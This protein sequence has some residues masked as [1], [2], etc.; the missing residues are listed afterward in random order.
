MA[1]TANTLDDATKTLL[2]NMFDQW[3]ALSILM[4]SLLG[5]GGGQQDVGSLARSQ[6]EQDTF[7]WVI[8]YLQNEPAETVINDRIVKVLVDLNFEVKDGIYPKF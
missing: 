2:L 3:L 7:L 1:S 5:M 8:E 6:T 4:P